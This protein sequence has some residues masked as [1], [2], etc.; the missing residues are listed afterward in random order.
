MAVKVLNGR[1][2]SS[3]PPARPRKV[4]YVLNLRTAYPEHRISEQTVVIAQKSPYVTLGTAT[5]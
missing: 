3:L 5:G 2:A 1:R 4:V